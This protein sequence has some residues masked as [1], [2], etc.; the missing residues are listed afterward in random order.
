MPSNNSVGS[1]AM[2][3]TLNTKSFDKQIDGAF[4]N[5]TR[6]A[7]N[8]A[9]QSES[10]FS[11]SFKK[12]GM[13]IAS[14]FAVKKV[15][16]FGKAC[17]ST[18]SQAQSAWTGLNSIVNGTGNNMATAQKF[19]TEYTRDGLVAVEDAATAYKNLLARGYDTS[20]I[21]S[22]MTALKDSAAFGRQASYTLSQAIV[23]AS[24]GLKNENSILVDNAGVTK[25]VAKMWD[26]YATSIGTTANNLTQQQKIQAEV[27]GI[28]TETK[29]QMG[30]AATYTSTFAGKIAQLKAAFTGMKVAIGKVVAPI[31]GIF[32][33]AITSAVNA[34]TSLFN[35]L[36]QFLSLFGLEFPDVVGKAAESTNIASKGMASVGDSASETTGKLAKTG[37][38]AQKAAKKINK[39]FSSVDEIN[40][41]RF[42]KPESSGGGSGGG[43]G[44]GGGAGAE[45]SSSSSGIGGA[46]EAVDS[47]NGAFDKAIEKINELKRAFSEGFNLGW[48][49]NS[50]QELFSDLDSIKQHLIDIF[51]N[52]EVIGAANNWLNSVIYAFGEVTGSVTAIGTNIATFL[53]GSIESYLNSNKKRIIDS[54]VNIFNIDS[55]RAKIVGEFSVVLAD[56]SKV[57]TSQTAQNI[58]GNVIAMFMNPFMSI[59]ELSAKLG[60]DIVDLIATPII[61]NKD[62]IKNAI[63]QTLKPL[64]TYTQTVAN[65]YTSLGD[66][67]NK[68]YDNN[69]KPL[70]NNIKNGVSNTFGKLLD[71]YNNNIAPFISNVGN[72]FSDT[73]NNHLKPFFDNVSDVIGKVIDLMSVLWD[74]RLKPVVDWIIQNIL[75]V[76][77][78]ILENMWKSFKLIFDHLVDMLKNFMKILGGVIDFIVGVFTGDWSRAWDGIKSVFTGIWDSI[79][80]T[81]E[82]IW[83]SIK[84]IVNTKIQE[85]K[86]V[87][88]VVFTTVKDFFKNTWDTITKFAKDAWTGIKNVWNTVKTWFVNN[89]INPIKTPF[90]NLWNTLK[91]GATNAW[92][93]IK[94]AFKS[95]GTFFG[96]IW[97]T[98]KSKFTNIGQKIGNAIGGAFKNAINAVLATAER[99]L[100]APIN[101]INGL[102]D[103]INQKVP[104]VNIGGRLSNINLPR[105]AEGAYFSKNNPTLAVVGDNTTQGEY[106]APEG[107][108]K[109]SVK[110]A[111]QE[112]KGNI[113]GENQKFDFTFR[114]IGDDGR[115]IIK[116][117]N[118]VT[119]QDGK[120]T[121]IV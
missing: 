119:I 3:L 7:K 56:I 66:N 82:F 28:L 77:V 26:E 115:T 111:I 45:S 37:T 35:R 96:G 110:E 101:T 103:T 91:T 114:M 38:A 55:E 9:S 108:L 14:A 12:I 10:V 2:D 81:F 58:G 1:V 76:V 31:V 25:N 44:G 102:I 85:V 63:N 40:V 5:A 11:S 19:L 29:F 73:W 100:N 17:V 104:G 43:A 117:I 61:D 88:T 98:I 47:G 89:V 24:E 80:G 20:Q 112:L 52:S 60:R 67:I 97:T 8:S 53:V 23:S 75:P 92:T 79:K 4:S 27:N 65:M 105:L 34:V 113:T 72:G 68:V 121:L 33:P 36:A 106:V 69:L 84:Q 71:V 41:L 18:A 83:N 39:A 59:M 99:V 51:T 118:D 22:V 46:V 16:D 87:I 32:I 62:K 64:E 78:P 54:I 13:T 109:Q 86:S 21:E 94:N 90:T 48:L 30:D 116:K 93:N 6:A 74:K 15:V 120:V 95:V 57:F 50:I 42:N 49:N 70:F 107:K